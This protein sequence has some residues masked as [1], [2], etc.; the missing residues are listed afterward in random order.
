[1]IDEGEDI[2][3]LEIDFSNVLSMINSGKICDGK[4]IMLL[5][6]AALHIFTEPNTK[7]SPQL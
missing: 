7:V 4:T 3:V 5:Q 2:T 6:Y 1:M